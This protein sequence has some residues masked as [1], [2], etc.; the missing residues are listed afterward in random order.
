MGKTLGKIKKLSKSAIVFFAVALLFLALGLGTLGSTEG[1]GEAFELKTER[2]S[3]TPTV[4]ARLTMGDS[5]NFKETYT[6][7]N[8]EEKERQYNIRITDVYVNLAVIYAE[9]GVPATLRMEYGSSETSYPSSRRIDAVFENFYTNAPAEGEEEIKPDV[10]GGQFRWVRP[11]QEIFER[12]TTWST[13]YRYVRFTAL[14]Q[15]LLINE[16]VFVGQKQ[17]RPEGKSDYEDTGE[18]IVIPAEVWSATPFNNETKEQSKAR[19][20]ALFDAQYIP[21]MAQSSYYRYSDDEIYTVSTI[22][23]MNRGGEYD[24]EIPSGA[25]PVDAVYNSLGT[26]IIA[27][28]TLI[29]GL[30]PFGLRFFS[31]LASFGV[32]VFG[33][34]LVR[35]LTKHDLA[36]LAFALLYVFCNLSFALGHLGNPLMIGVFFFV[37]SLYFCHKFYARGMKKAR[38]AGVLPPILSGLFG[39]AAISVNGVYLIPVA[40]VVALFVLGMVRQQKAKRHYLALAEAE[41]EGAGETAERVVSAKEEVERE[42]RDKNVAAALGFGVML[43]V[44]SLLFALLFVIPLYGPYARLYAGG[45]TNIF[46]LAWN[47]FAGGYV[48][49][50]PG[51]SHCAWDLFYELFKGAGTSYAITA[52]V[53]NAAAA[54]AGLG[55]VAFACWR[56]AA[57]ARGKKLEKEQRAEL[58]RVLV[59]LAGLVLS[60]LFS[61]FGGG[62]LAFILLSY[63][64]SFVLT[65][66]AFAFLWESPFRKPVKIGC[67]AGL[68]LLIAVFLLYSVFT[69]SVPLPASLLE[70]IF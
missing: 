39:A 36:A 31:M 5:T 29:F 38:G 19:A 23:E 40:G 4:V 21:S 56:I 32:L 52:A 26:D 54:L 2:G 37:A 57:V 10:T 58:R 53:I 59:P 49:S 51:A 1:V 33:Y 48:G 34:L 68:V 12:S 30:N 16:I 17:V 6:D 28:G 70:S 55:G 35:A 62:A 69:F 11:F 47:A 24:S 42:Y 22:A 18:A 43:V 13:N 3:N 61:W 65:A 45:S 20:E 9:A 60:F 63:L 44:C 8:G 15:N 25:Y 41:G 7:E 67:V 14:T 66:E 64:F 46:A 27:L 50:N